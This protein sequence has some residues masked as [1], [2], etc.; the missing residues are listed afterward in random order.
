MTFI[1]YCILAIKE[2]FEIQYSYCSNQNNAKHVF[3]MTD[4][5]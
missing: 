1:G 2:E 5:F 4:V 3:K